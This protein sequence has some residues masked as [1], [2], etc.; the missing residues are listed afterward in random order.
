MRLL[1]LARLPTDIVPLTSVVRYGTS[2]RVPLNYQGSRL[3]GEATL[4]QLSEYVTEKGIRE[5]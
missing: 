2:E 4:P 3:R 5:I 1:G